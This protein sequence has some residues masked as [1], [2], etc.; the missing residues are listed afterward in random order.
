MPRGEWLRHLRPLIYLACG[1]A[2]LLDLMDSDTLAFGVFYIPLVC[3]AVLSGNRRSVW[4][5]AGLSILLVAV[6]AFIP[7][8]NPDHYDLI[9]NRALSAAAILATAALVSHTWRIRE[10]L[11]EQ[12]RRAEAAE[13][14][15]TEIFTNLG[16][17]LRQ[18]LHA[19]IGL[20]QLMAVDCRP[21]QREP[22]G[23]VQLASRRLLSTINNLV[24]LTKFEERSPRSEPVDINA[25]LQGA[26][27]EV[28]HRAHDGQVAVVT[29][30]P[31]D[32]RPLTSDAWAARRIVENILDNA[33]K[34]TPP[35]GSVKVS[36]APTSGAVSVIVTDTGEGMPEDVL[37]SIGQPLFQT[38]PA[39]DRRFEGVGT[40]LALSRQLADA[41]GAELQFESTPGFGTSA[42]VRFPIDDNG[43]SGQGAGA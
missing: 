12:T 28:R 10:C 35:G 43:R 1:V 37:S 29:D 20:T 19:I 40:G 4:W 33:V 11:T 13:K 8:V 21:N 5:L 39:I 27:D 3:T 2:F 23:H 22:L 42:T 36:A 14:L 31:S 32:L 26:I 15:K 17:D 34:F 9:G 16:Y 24:D 41:I 18:P 38:D 25:L 7:T 6:G 30:I